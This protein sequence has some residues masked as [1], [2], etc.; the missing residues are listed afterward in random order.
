MTFQILALSGGG[1]LGL[2]SAHILAQI[3]EQAKR[4]LGRCFDLICGTSI[5]G[6]I[7]LGL[8]N[9]VPAATILQAFESRGLEI[10]PQKPRWLGRLSDLIQFG[11]RPKY[12]GCALRRTIE[13]ILGPATLLGEAKHRVL[14]PAVNMTEGKIQVFKTPHHVNFHLDH[15]KRMVDIAMATSAAPLYLPMAEI[16]DAL[17]VDGGLYANAPDLCAIHEAEHFLNIPRGEISVLSIG[18]TTSSYSLPHSLG[19]NFGALEWI[20]MSGDTSNCPPDAMRNCP[21]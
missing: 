19:R 20:T 3:E 18:T 10:F 12:D 8:A 6:I 13:D 21:P 5:G 11:F 4:P 17:Y 1:Y 14:I 15:R 16:D 7:A 9:E 2:F